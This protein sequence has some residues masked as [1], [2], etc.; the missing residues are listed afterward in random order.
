M[1]NELV[2]DPEILRIAPRNRRRMA[3][4]EHRFARSRALRRLASA[5][6]VAGRTSA[7]PAVL[8][9]RSSRVTLHWLAP[10]THYGTRWVGRPPGTARAQPTTLEAAMARV[11]TGDAIVLRGGSYRTGDLTLNQG[12]T[13]QPHADERPVLKGTQV[14]TK[15]EAQSN[16]LWRTSWT[17]LFPARPASWWRREREGKKTPLYRFNNDMVFVDGKLLRTVGSESEIDAH[18]Y[19]IDYQAGQVYL[20][21]DPTNRL[22]EITAFDHAL[23]RTIGNTHGKPSDRKG[24][25][26]RGLTFTQYAFRAIEIEGKNPEGLSDPATFGKD[27]VGT[28]LEHVTSPIAPGSAVTSGDK[29]TIRHCRV[30]DTS[31]EGIFILS[32]RRCPPGENI[33]PE[34]TSR[35]SPLLSRGGEDLQPRHRVTCRDNL[36]IDQPKLNGIW[37]D[38]GNVDGRFYNN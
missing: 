1:T 9:A 22:V 20:G 34:T 11:V 18:S 29:L 13:L 19:Y 25:L 38:V 33:L 6:G 5:A 23:T 35:K 7:S 8:M 21:V 4:P 3:Q 24:P 30:S 27:V 26:I 28:T 14:A 15:W 31:M 12:I 37:H 16:G 32:S 2:S 36:V 17:R 10:F